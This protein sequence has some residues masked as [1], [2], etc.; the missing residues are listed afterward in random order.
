MRGEGVRVQN[1]PRL[2]G[3]DPGYMDRQLLA[4]REGARRSQRMGPIARALNDDQ[5]EA[6]ERYY[7]SLP[8]AAEGGAGDAKLVALGRSLSE[9]GDWSE[10]VPACVSCHGVGGLGVGS[11]S[12][13]IA[14][15]RADYL[16]RQLTRFR[17]GDRKDD[18]LG[19]MR[20]IAQRLSKS[21]IEAVAAFY[22][23]QPAAPI[24]PGGPGSS[25]HAGGKS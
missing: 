11:F 24:R 16:K 8:A 23:T 18:P 4:F 1:A 22:A 9:Q 19:L 12:P 10:R 3:L 17:D 7:A 2:A 20:G 6:V 15:Q 5:R 13:P 21:E 25:P 14:G